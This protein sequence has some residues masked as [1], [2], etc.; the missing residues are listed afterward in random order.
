M[1]R[2]FSLVA[3][4][5]LAPTGLLILAAPQAANAVV[6]GHG[7][8]LC[9]VIQGAGTVSPGLTPIGSPGGV[10]INFHATIGS[11]AGALCGGTVTS[12]A[13]DHVRGGSLIGSGYYNAPIP[14][15][16]GSSCSNFAGPDIVG[17]IKVTI[18]WTMTGPPIA[19][20]VV[21]Y[22]LNPATVAGAGVDT[23]T[24]KAPGGTAVK[25]GSFATGLLNTTRLKTTLPGPACGPGPWAAFGIN[26][27]N[28]SM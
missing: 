26:G 9:N 10:K 8:A 13:G 21:V 5:V 25:T 12:P 6:I 4:A 11:P 28:V 23:I 22:K 20:T 14:T 2:R 24:L 19:N 15:A 7:T 17:Q 27:G 3:A 16:H 1:F 18:S